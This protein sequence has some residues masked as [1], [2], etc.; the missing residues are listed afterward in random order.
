ML[1]QHN[2]N[3]AMTPHR[4]IRVPGPISKC[5]LLIEPGDTQTRRRG[6][7]NLSVPRAHWHRQH[8]RT[9]QPPEAA[10]LPLVNPWQ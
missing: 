5:D 7:R 6:R 8:V 2:P 3:D 10:T 9:V 1:L 4:R